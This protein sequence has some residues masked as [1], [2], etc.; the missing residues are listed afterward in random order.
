MEI[1]FYSYCG[2]L[3]V[4]TKFALIGQ[5]GCER[6]STLN[7]RRTAVA[8]PSKAVASA[9]TSK[10]KKASISA[11]QRVPTLASRAAA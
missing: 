5:A 11:G 10:H 9:A 6:S 3:Y 4:G 8:F 2:Q 1:G 7:Q